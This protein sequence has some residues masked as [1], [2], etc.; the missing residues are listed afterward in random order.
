MNYT[1]DERKTIDTIRSSCVELFGFLIDNMSIYISNL[2]QISDHRDRGTPLNLQ[3]ARKSPKEKKPVAELNEEPEP[4]NKSGAAT[5]AWVQWS[6]STTG[7]LIGMTTL[8]TKAQWVDF[9]LPPTGSNYEDTTNYDRLREINAG[10]RG[11]TGR[12]VI[13]L[14]KLIEKIQRDDEALLACYRY[15]MRISRSVSRNEWKML[16][17]V[18]RSVGIE[19]PV[20][21]DELQAVRFGSE[22][23]LYFKKTL[24]GLPAVKDV[25]ALYKKVKR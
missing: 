11:I 20:S 10:M 15:L 6:T 17:K 14:T 12:Y 21:S 3:K 23:R 4:N 25:G 22:P 9:S 5:A 2:K 16:L 13:T 18:F 24:R 7:K 19:A 8:G 1:E